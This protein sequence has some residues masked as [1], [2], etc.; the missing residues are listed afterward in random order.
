L[1]T[2]IDPE[3]SHA[4]KVL[5][6]DYAD[7]LMG[8]GFRGRHGTAVLKGVVV[9]TEYREAVEAVIEGFHDER[10]AIEE[11][12]RSHRA[13]RMWKRFLISLRIKERI[14]GYAVEGEDEV[15]QEVVPDD[16]DSGVDEEYVDDDGGGFF[17]DE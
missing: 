9:A 6:I 12:M 11:Q 1:L 5:G 10:A 8:F 2:N 4:A 16:E 13:L 14:D 17:P 3:A 7:A 15:E